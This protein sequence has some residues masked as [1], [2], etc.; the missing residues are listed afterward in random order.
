MGAVR[1][2]ARCRQPPRG[3]GPCCGAPGGGGGMRVGLGLLRV[4]PPLADFLGRR[5]ELAREWGVGVGQLPL[6]VV[7][8]GSSPAAVADELGE[9]IP[10]FLVYPDAPHVVSVG[11]HQPRVRVGP[12]LWQQGGPRIE[13]FGVV[14]AVVHGE[15]TTLDRATHVALY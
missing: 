3:V 14:L 13:G 1:A 6:D 5:T 9:R 4:W 12:F 2:R 10:E 11:G 7:P 15:H 8:D